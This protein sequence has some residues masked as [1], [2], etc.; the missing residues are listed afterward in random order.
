MRLSP[1]ELLA[2]FPGRAIVRQV[3]NGKLT[4][5]DSG[6][7]HTVYANQV[8]RVNQRE[9]RRKRRQQTHRRLR[10]RKTEWGPGMRLPIPRALRFAIRMRLKCCWR[11][12]RAT[13]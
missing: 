7:L 5:P 3:T 1:A 11:W 4:M 9:K 13:G 2:R 6:L 10:W 8:S 12:R